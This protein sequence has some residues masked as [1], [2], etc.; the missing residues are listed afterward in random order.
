MRSANAWGQK[1]DEPNQDKKETILPLHFSI[2]PSRVWMTS[3]ISV[4]AD[5]LY[6]V[7]WSKC[8]PLPETPSQIHIFSNLNLSL[9]LQF[10]IFNEEVLC[11]E[12]VLES[13]RI[14]CKGKERQ[15]SPT[16]L[17][18]F[19][20][21]TWLFIRLFLFYIKVCFMRKNCIHR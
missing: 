21:P 18:K 12:K 6:L 10:L 19:S 3:A 14:T 5:L 11:F 8:W 7:F 2:C 16:K 15:W 4:R 1:M 9:S 17:K 13:Y 20:K